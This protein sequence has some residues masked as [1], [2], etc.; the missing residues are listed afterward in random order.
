MKV[1]SNTAGNL[2]SL[3]INDDILRNNFENWCGDGTL[4]V[5]PGW[6]ESLT[7]E[8]LMLASLSLKEGADV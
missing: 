1:K 8:F 5:P 7:D 3:L 2:F 6:R 4:A